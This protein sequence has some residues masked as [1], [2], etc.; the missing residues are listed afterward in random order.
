MKKIFSLLAA[1]VTLLALPKTNFGQAPN[2]GTAANY[3]L[4]TSVG[5]V[6]NSGI[7]YLTRVTGNVGT[8]SAPTITGFG[9]VDGVMTYT[10][11]S[12]SAQCASDLL[13]ASDSLAKVKIDSTLGLVIGGYTLRPGNYLMPGAASLNGNLT[14]D[15]KGNANAVFILVTSKAFSSTANSRITLKNGALACNVFWKLDGAVSIGTSNVMRGTIISA[16]AITLGVGDTLEG[17]AL[18]TNGAVM[19]DSLLAYTPIGCSSPTLTGPAF[20]P[21]GSTS[22]YG[23]FSGNGAVTN[24]GNTYVTGDV[25]TNVGLTTGYNPL[26]VTG[27]IHP[28]PDASTAACAKDLGTLYNYLDS[29]KADIQLLYPAQF[30]H[31]LVLTP[32][33]YIMKSAVT[34]VDTLYLNA[35]GDANAVFAILINGALSTGAFA[36]VKLI[37]GAQAKNVFWKVDG[38]V[39]LASNTVFMGTIVANNGAIGMHSLAVTTGGVF[40]TNGQLKTDTNTITNTTTCVPAGIESINGNGKQAVVVYPNPFNTLLTIMVND[41]LQ[42]DTYQVKVYNVLGKE[43]MSKA[44]T[45]KTTTLGTSTLPSGMY[46]Y[47]VLDNETLVQSGKVISTK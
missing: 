12:L 19:C 39:N 34:F 24:F 20:P 10:G 21:L 26:F 15:A 9:N 30:G 27:T 25:G 32:H 29:L 33:I 37:N 36:K 42:N 1:S 11:S 47:Q 14:L 31:S 45:E 41:M 13:A 43:V 18:T 16:S 35:E 40:T 46:F 28:K 17:R 22:C 4:F 7:T 23:V 3:A 8:N 5:S 2:L 44:I 6:T 38:A